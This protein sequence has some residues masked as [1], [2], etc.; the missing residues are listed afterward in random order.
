M[1]ASEP[2][3]QQI[4]RMNQQVAAY[5]RAGNIKE[6]VALA[7]EAFFTAVREL[8]EAHFL[9][10]QSAR[11]RGIMQQMS[12][13]IAEAAKTFVVA[14]DFYKKT[15]DACAQRRRELDSSGKLQEAMEA[16]KEQTTLA[17]AIEQL[18]HV[19]F[20]GGAHG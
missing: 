4:A 15:L 3:E 12:G 1:E 18:Q 11:N 9:R 6:G 7:D 5:Q 16:A 20:G 19:L 2:I 14:L 8:P 17:R 10:A 13:N